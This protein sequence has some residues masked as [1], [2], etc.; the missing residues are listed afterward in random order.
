MIFA[1]RCNLQCIK[2]QRNQIKITKGP[3]IRATVSFNLSCNNVALQVEIVCCAYY[4][5]LVQQISILQKVDVASTF[6]N[7]KNLLHEKVV[8]RATNNLNLQRNIVARQVERNCYP[9]YLAFSNEL[10]TT[11]NILAFTCQL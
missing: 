3:V 2:E 9:Y 10:R 6:C 4:H 1:F 11:L 7:I 5:L 8:I